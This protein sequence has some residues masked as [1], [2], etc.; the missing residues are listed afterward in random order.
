MRA[1]RSGGPH[2]RYSARPL[3]ALKKDGGGGRGSLSLAAVQVSLLGGQVGCDSGG[4]GDV[5]G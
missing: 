1:G 4:G 2:C 5:R 3:E